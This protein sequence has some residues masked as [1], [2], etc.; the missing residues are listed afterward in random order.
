MLSSQREEEVSYIHHDDKATSDDTAITLYDDDQFR[1]SPDRVYQV[2]MGRVK[3]LR[4]L[5]FPREPA[6]RNKHDATND[7]TIVSFDDD[8]LVAMTCS[9]LVYNGNDL[10]HDMAQA[11]ERHRETLQQLA[12]RLD[13]LDAFK[14]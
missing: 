9:D 7:N 6:S 8:K 11:Q 10:V 5:V 12:I 2:F 4:R 1:V 3:L 14:K 13:K